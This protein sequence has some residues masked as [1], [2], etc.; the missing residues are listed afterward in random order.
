MRTQKMA[1]YPHTPADEYD[2]DTR[3]KIEAAEV[4]A[5]SAHFVSVAVSR[6]DYKDLLE[7]MRF[8]RQINPWYK[9]I[10][11]RIERLALRIRES[12]DHK[13]VP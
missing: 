10:G 12:L 8:I 4:A 1:E 6:Q 11:Q 3:A 13:G 5:K 9:T 7:A 2:R